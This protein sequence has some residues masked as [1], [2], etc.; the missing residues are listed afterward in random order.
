MKLSLRL[1]WW[2]T[3]CL[4]WFWLFVMIVGYA[5]FG[6]NNNEKQL[7]QQDSVDLIEALLWFMVYGLWS[8]SSFSLLFIVVVKNRS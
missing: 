5:I 1:L 7:L 8:W 6:N 4:F 2:L 3:Y